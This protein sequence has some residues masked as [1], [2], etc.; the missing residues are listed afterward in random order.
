MDLGK[1]ELNLQLINYSYHLLKYVSRD[2]FGQ[3]V[4]HINFSPTVGYTEKCH[5]SMTIQKPRTS[6]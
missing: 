5:N 6:C 1:L 4:V 3:S 2:V